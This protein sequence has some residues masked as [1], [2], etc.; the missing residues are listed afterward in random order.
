MM[1][2]ASRQLCR[3]WSSCAVMLSRV[4]LEPQAKRRHLGSF[5]PL[6][7]GNQPYYASLKILRQSANNK[8]LTMNINKFTSDQNVSLQNISTRMPSGG[9]SQP[10]RQSK[11]DDSIMGTNNSS[12]VSKRSVERL[13]YPEPHFFRYFVKRPQRRSPLINRGYWLRMH[14]VEQVVRRFLQEPTQMR[15]VVLNLG[16]G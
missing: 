5:R 4:C 9:S 3:C 7:G 16:C 2:H 12:I 13:Y 6:N 8:N 14:A 15:K 10:S 11:Q 1:L